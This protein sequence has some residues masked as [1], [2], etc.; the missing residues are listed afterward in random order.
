MKK[1]KKTITLSEEM[2]LQYHD[3]LNP[4]LW[5]GDKLKSEVRSKLLIIAK[6]WAAFANIDSDNIVDIIFLYV[7][8]NK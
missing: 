1:F 4:K 6:T 2:T 5:I 8:R 3:S 7:P